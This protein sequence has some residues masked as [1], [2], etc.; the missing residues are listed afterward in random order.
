MYDF[1][2][3]NYT[4]LPHYNNRENFPIYL[5]LVGWLVTAA[6][7]N[8][9]RADRADSHPD[10]SPPLAPLSRRNRWLLWTLP[11]VSP[12]RLLTRWRLRALEGAAETRARAARRWQRWRTSSP[13]SRR[14]RFQ[15]PSRWSSRWCRRYRGYLCDGSPVHSKPRWWITNQQLQDLSTRP[16]WFGRSAVH[17]LR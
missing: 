3:K 8:G 15:C 5:M 2:T 16:N 17:F 1:E 11:V 4:R 9:L 12:P 13:G 10:R 14:G 6:F 7:C